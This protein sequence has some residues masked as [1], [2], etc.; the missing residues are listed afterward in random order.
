MRKGPPKSFG[1]IQPFFSLEKLSFSHFFGS[2]EP[3]L[4][5]DHKLHNICWVFWRGLAP[6]KFWSHTTILLIGPTTFFDISE[7]WVGPHEKMILWVQ[8]FGHDLSSSY[9]TI[10]VLRSQIRPK[11][12][13]KVKK[14]IR[15]MS[16]APWKNGPR[17]PKLW[18]WPILI[19]LH[20]ICVAIKNSFFSGAFKTRQVNTVL[21]LLFVST[22]L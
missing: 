22:L 8:N 19:I 15:K 13:K 20:D 2:W 18:P 14:L 5:W 3:H 7:N 16:G 1:V 17:T 9:Y 21:C 11:L 12:T 6:W 4:R 10:Y